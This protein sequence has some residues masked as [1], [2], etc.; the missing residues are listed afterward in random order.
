MADSVTVA[1]RPA[2]CASGTTSSTVRTAASVVIPWLRWLNVSLAI[3]TRLTSSTAV[4]AARSKPR[5]LRTRPMS[6]ARAAVPSVDE[7]G[8]HGFGVGHPRHPGRVHEAGDLGPGHAGVDGPTYEL[9]LLGRGQLGVV[10]LQAVARSDLDDGD[11]GHVDTSL[12][13]LGSD[14]HHGRF[15]TDPGASL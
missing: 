15:P 14:L 2:A 3:T 5:A 7:P 1:T 11:V 8:D 4:A 12:L 6:A 10:V 13:R 9:D